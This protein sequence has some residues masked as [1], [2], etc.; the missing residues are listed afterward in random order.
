MT[1]PRTAAAGVVALTSLCVACTS[2]QPR[3]QSTAAA[4]IRAAIRVGDRVR[5]VTR[6]GERRDLEVTSLGDAGVSGR[7]NGKWWQDP[8]TLRETVVA[9]DS[10]Q[11]IEVR[12]FDRVLTTLLAAVGVIAIG[13][14]IDHLNQPATCHTGCGNIGA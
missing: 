12:R 9:F 6:D 3:T 4:E 8:N 2:L 5:T 1:L 7:V 14:L 13:W 11:S 10:I